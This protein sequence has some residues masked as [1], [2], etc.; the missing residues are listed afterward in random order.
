LEVAE[1]EGS[2]EWG[3]EVREEEMF[4]VEPLATLL[5]RLRDALCSRGPDAPPEASLLAA[6]QQVCKRM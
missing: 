5:T 3:H 1:D 4:V 2:V 6:M